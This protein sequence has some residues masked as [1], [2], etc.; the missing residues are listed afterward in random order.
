MRLFRLKP[1]QRRRL[2]RQLKAASDARFYRRTLAVLELDRGRSAAEIAHMLGVTRQSVHNWANRSLRDDAPSALADRARSGRTRLL[3]ED[4]EDLIRLL[5]LC[6]PQDLG[7]PHTDW[8]VPLLQSEVGD[9][10]G[11]RPSESTI[12]RVLRQLGYVWKR[13]RYFLEPDPEREKKTLYP[14][15]NPLVAPSER[16]TRRG[17]DRPPVVPAVASRMV[18]ARRAS[19]SL[20]ERQERSSG[21]LWGDEPGDGNAVVR[22]A[23]QGT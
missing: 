13:P 21:D 11:E 3:T 5:L 12:R 18:V 6:S 9:D 1:W 14:S 10:T 17:R 7:H 8:T 20:V 22:A 19:G 4:D 2:Q 15:A 23:P 16:R